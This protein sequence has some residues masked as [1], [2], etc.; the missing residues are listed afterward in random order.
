MLKETK[1]ATAVAKHKET[2]I[3][4]LEEKIFMF[5]NR[6]ERKEVCHA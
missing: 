2:K 5:F 1:S 6:P 4:I 3:D